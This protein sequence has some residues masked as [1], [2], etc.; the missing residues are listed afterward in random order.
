MKVYEDCRLPHTTA[1][2]KS[3][4]EAADIYSQFGEF[5]AIVDD[6]ERYRRMAEKLE[7]WTTWIWKYDAD[8]E[9]RTRLNG[10]RSKS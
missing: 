8:V 3:S 10:L 6:E 1:V 2:Q 9:I 5:E 7:A 4:R